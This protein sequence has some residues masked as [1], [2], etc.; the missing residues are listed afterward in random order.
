MS[1]ITSLRNMMGHTCDDHAR[2]AS[3]T[4]KISEMCTR[5]HARRVKLWQD[6]PISGSKE[7]G[8]VPSVPVL[9]SL[10]R[11]TQV[12]SPKR[13][14]PE[15]IEPRGDANIARGGS[16]SPLLRRRTTGILLLVLAFLL[17]NVNAYY[18]STYSGRTDWSSFWFREAIIGALFIAIIVGALRKRP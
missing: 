10:S 1:R 14:L 3:H 17:Y 8:S 16:R 15:P 13:E 6:V 5:P 4:V 9:L 7:N 2:K 12:M 11:S 18:G